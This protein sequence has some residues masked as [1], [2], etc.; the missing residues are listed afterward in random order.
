PID[1]IGRFLNGLSYRTDDP[2]RCC[3]FMREMIE[4]SGNGIEH[5]GKVVDARCHRLVAG[6]EQNSAAFASCLA[7]FLCRPFVSCTALMCCS[8]A[9]AGDLAPTLQVHRCKSALLLGH[10]TLSPS[11]GTLRARPTPRPPVRA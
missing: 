9:F 1:R 11:R 3:G 7:R 6:T 10:S 4:R 8:T 5:C 2:W